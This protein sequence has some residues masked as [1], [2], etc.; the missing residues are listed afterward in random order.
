MHP[1]LQ[2]QCLVYSKH[3][4]LVIQVKIEKKRGQPG[5]AVVK[6]SHS[7]LAAWGSLVQIP[8]MNQSTACQAMLWQMYHT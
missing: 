5:G 6:F 8:G 3:I 2:A 7:A 4:I 1:E